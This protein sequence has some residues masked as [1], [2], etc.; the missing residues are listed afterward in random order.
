MDLSHIKATV[1]SLAI[2]NIEAVDLTEGSQSLQQVKAVCKT[3][4]YTTMQ[5]K[6]AV[7]GIPSVTVPSLMNV[8]DDEHLYC[9]RY[10]CPYSPEW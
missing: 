7:Q 3:L 5:S 10:Q 2:T 8:D 6:V 9:F 4:N 1:V